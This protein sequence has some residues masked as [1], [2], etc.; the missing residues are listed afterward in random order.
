MKFLAFMV[1]LLGTATLILFSG[2]T[3]PTWLGLVVLITAVS[4]DFTTTWLCLRKG[5]RE[6]N[7]VIAFLFGKIGVWKTFGVMVGIWTCFIVF[8]WLGS[9][10]GIQTAVA[11]SYFLVP[12]NNLM[13]L[14]KLCRRDQIRETA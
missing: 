8:R 12:M 3:L 5:G 10:E 4:S 7:P 2:F 1:L 13:V 11:F 9:T 14:R 6:G